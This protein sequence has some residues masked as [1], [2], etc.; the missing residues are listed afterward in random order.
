MRRI[1]SKGR[2]AGSKRPGWLFK[3]WQKVVTKRDGVTTVVRIP[4]N[5]S[6][7]TGYPVPLRT[8]MCPD[9]N[10]FAESLSECLYFSCSVGFYIYTIPIRSRSL[11]ANR[12]SKKWKIICAPNF[13]LF[14]IFNISC[15]VV[16]QIFRTTRYFALKMFCDLLLS[17]I[18]LCDRVTLSTTWITLTHACAGA[19]ERQRRHW[20]KSA[21][22]RGTSTS[23]RSRSKSKKKEKWPTDCYGVSGAKT[24]QDCYR[25]FYY[26]IILVSF[27]FC[28]PALLCNV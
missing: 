17:S 27:N 24:V 9:P 15:S 13:Q 19:A 16:D 12:F 8:R 23:C 7:F 28:F 26:F 22:L 5:T 21:R 2:V 18:F 10:Y 20:P 11:L 6:L 25:S 4:T 14:I 3:S 1:L